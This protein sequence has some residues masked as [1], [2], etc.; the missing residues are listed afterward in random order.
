MSNQIV[1]TI[2]DIEDVYNQDIIEENGKFVCPV[3]SK[4]YK[5]KSSA[6]KHLAKE[7]CLS[8]LDMFKN[9]TTE[10]KAYTHYKFLVGSV[11]PNATVSLQI[12]K[13]SPAYNG[14]IRLTLFLMYHEMLNLFETYVQWLVEFKR[15]QT[16][17]AILSVG[18]KE[19][20]L[21]DFRVF[22]HIYPQFIDND[23]FY[24]SYRED[25]IED[26]EFLVRSLEKAKISM[27]YLLSQEDFPFEE[28]MQK[29]EPGYQ[30]RVEELAEKVLK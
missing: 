18:V 17:H 27:K 1:K 29:M 22:L 10:I 12:F 21:A 30:I 6:E 28:V 8:L 9:T 16:I 26:S 4:S 3:C 14:C 2:N 23:K 7:D 20:V 15:S 11:N 19:S 24:R 13:K 25:L 5:R